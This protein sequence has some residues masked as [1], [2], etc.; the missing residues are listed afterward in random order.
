MSFFEPEYD[1]LHLDYEQLRRQKSA[2][3]LEMDYVDACKEIGIIKNYKVSLEGCTC[4]DFSRRHKP[5]KHMYC[6]AMELGV[7]EVDAAELEELTKTVGNN[8]E[9]GSNIQMYP[10]KYEYITCATP[11]KDYV[12]IDFETANNRADSVC[13]LGIAVVENNS[14]VETKSYL[15]RPPYNDFRNSRIHGIKLE[16]VR[17]KKT[18]RELWEEI[19]PYIEGRTVA[20]YNLFFDLGCLFATIE[21]YGIEKPFFRAFDILAYLK[22]CKQCKSYKLTSVSKEFGLKHKAHDAESD[23]KVAAEIEILLAQEFSGVTTNIYYLGEQSIFEAVAKSRISIEM[24]IDYT[25]EL[26]KRD[27]ELNYDAY[28]SLLKLLEQVAAHNDSGQLYQNCGMLYEKFGKIKRALSYYKKALSLDA[29]LKLKT[30]IQ[31][32][33]SELKKLGA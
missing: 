10:V 23:S 2:L 13:Q 20:A 3:S 17:D 4:T 7:F 9:C 24:V 33:E 5:C 29:N 31:R 30:K 19:K 32:L 6:L 1:D 15:I 26:I 27:E 8:K 11:P 22:L 14:I 28:K 21:Y 25:K 16:D 12:V 18:F